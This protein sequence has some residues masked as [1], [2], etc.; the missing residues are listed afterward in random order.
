MNETQGDLL[1]LEMAR[2]RLVGIENMVH[3]L[4]GQVDNYRRQ[5]WRLEDQ[6]IELEEELGL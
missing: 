6:I 1:R 4:E 5:Q 3:H 2:K